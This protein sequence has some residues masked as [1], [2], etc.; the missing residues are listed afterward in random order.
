M[1]GGDWADRSYK[2]LTESSLSLSILLNGRRSEQHE[3]G[4][5]VCVCGGGVWVV[6]ENTTDMQTLQYLSQVK[7]WWWW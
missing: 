2:A 1:R 7:G 6:D 5:G 4:L 3:K